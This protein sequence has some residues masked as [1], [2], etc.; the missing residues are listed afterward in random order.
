VERTSV[1]EYGFLGLRFLHTSCYL[2]I[3][4]FSI[5][6][7]STIH[8]RL[9]YTTLRATQPLCSSVFYL[10]VSVLISHIVHTIT[11]NSGSS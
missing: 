5:P 1:V 4:L 9:S 2:L 6:V 3:Y 8:L 10:V 11:Q 7:I